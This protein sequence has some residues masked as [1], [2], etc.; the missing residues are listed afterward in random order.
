MGLRDWGFGFEV[1]LRD[2][3]VVLLEDL[4][5]LRPWTVLGKAPVF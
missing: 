1:E 4:T 2:Y 3:F 5:M